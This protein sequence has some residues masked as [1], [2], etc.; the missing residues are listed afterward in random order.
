MK[1]SH[2]AAVSL[3]CLG[4]GQ[5]AEAKY[6]KLPESCQYIFHT[7]KQ[8]ASKKDLYCLVKLASVTG[9]KETP[10]RMGQGTREMEIVEFIPK[11]STL[12]IRVDFLKLPSAKKMG[13]EK[14][15]RLKRRVSEAL[16]KSSCTDK[17]LG[18]VVS[19]GGRVEYDIRN[20]AGGR[21]SVPIHKGTCRRYWR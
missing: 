8:S 7:D 9:N 15:S 20:R 14:W 10:T 5:F 4:Y 17:S 13:K 18:A 1:I 6:L 2:L 3:L 19:F 11:K 12:V 21:F 16:S